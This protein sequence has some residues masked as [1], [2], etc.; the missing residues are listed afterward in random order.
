[1]LA[2]EV[3]LQKQIAATSRTGGENEPRASCLHGL[4]LAF[5]HPDR[6]KDPT[7][8]HSLRSG[9]I[10]YDLSQWPA[11]LADGLRL[12]ELPLLASQ[13]APLWVFGSPAP[14]PGFG[15]WNRFQ[16]YSLNSR[17]STRE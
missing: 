12:E 11:G 10:R 14:L 13:D 3:P 4:H 6:Q 16:A 7:G 9:H 2:P 15:L 17:L 5:A 8:G 1:M